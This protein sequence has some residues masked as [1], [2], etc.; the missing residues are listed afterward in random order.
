MKY[1]IFTSNDIIVNSGVIAAGILASL[2]DSKIPD[3]IIGAIVFS[4]VIRGSIRIL[5]LSPVM[6]N[7]HLIL[8]FQLLSVFEICPI[9]FAFSY[10]IIYFV[11]NE[12]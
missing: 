11:I 1:N 9:F 12:N 5:K 2:L 4:F 10:I 3:L 6:E 8:N 7:L